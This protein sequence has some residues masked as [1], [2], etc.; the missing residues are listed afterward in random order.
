MKTRGA[1]E[2]RLLVQGEIGEGEFSG[3][4][5]LLRISFSG[6]S[7]SL[8]TICKS[9]LI[10]RA[11]GRRFEGE[12]ALGESGRGRF[13]TLWG[14]TGGAE[15]ACRRCIQALAAWRRVPFLGDG[16]EGAAKAAW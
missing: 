8:S 3:K 4:G 9:V 13:F 6:D 16:R 10:L 14:F 7:N 15:T 12:R 11:R 2:G 1:G 5:E